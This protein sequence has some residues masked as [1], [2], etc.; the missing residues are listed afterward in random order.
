M[1]CSFAPRPMR[2]PHELARP[3]LRSAL[4]LAAAAGIGLLARSAAAQA[5]PPPAPPPDVTPP[6]VVQHVDAVYPASALARREH[7]DVMLA[8]TVDADG[9]V[10]KVD[11]MHSGGPDLDE[12]AITAS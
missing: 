9:H 5:T 8:L 1:K 10:S 12:A 3:G 2:P 7:A 6:A 4:A 11:V